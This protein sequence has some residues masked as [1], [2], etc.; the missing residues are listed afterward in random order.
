MGKKINFEVENFDIIEEEDS[1]SQFATAKVMAFATGVNKHDLVC[2]E[3]VLRR[4]ANTLY[5]KPLIYNLDPIYGDFG[6]HTTPEKSLIAGFCVPDSGEFIQL[7]DSRIGFSV[8]VKL[9]K[10]YAPIAMNILK[11]KFTKSVSVEMDLLDS[12]TRDDGLVDMKSFVFSSICLLGDLIN[13]AIESASLE[14]LSFSKEKEDYI[15]AYKQEFSKYDNVELEIPL[16]V[17]Q[18]VEKGLQ[19]HKQNG[20]GTSIALS[21]AHHLIKNEKVSPEK[22]RHIAKVHRSK[23]VKIKKHSS[24]EERTM[25]MLYGGNEG[26]EWAQNIEV[27]LND[28]DAMDVSYFNSELTFPYQNRDDMNPALRGINPPI[29]IEQGEEIAK[30]AESIGNDEDK[31]GWSIAISNFKKTHTVGDNKWVKK[32]TIHNAED[33]KEKEDIKKEDMIDEKEKDLEK[34]KV[35]TPEEEKKE[36]PKEEEKEKKEGI[37]KPEDKKEEKMSNDAFLDV[38]AILGLL[39]DETDSYKELAAEFES[40]EGQKDFSKLCNAMYSKMCKM[41]EDAK[42]Y[43]A[44]NEELKKFKA[45]VEAGNK[46]FE[47]KSALKEVEYVLPKEEMESLYADSSNFSLGEIEIWKNK[48]KARAFSLVNQKNEKE[49]VNPDVVKI[50]LPFAGMSNKSKSLWG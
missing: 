14:M 25:F 46:D 28:L 11:D 12:E 4:T 22:V 1:N 24:L 16:T 2:S 29:S 30:Q 32:E 41:A 17:K 21:V 34:E 8:L 3:E 20:K 10:R 19:L 18:N 42:T 6:S 5:S 26:Q 13:P 37:E 15:L 39:A 45:D 40:P 33:E 49:E 48:V 9:W 35:E 23:F 43:M 47:V 50:G 38:G 27:K 36:T 31:N 44:E 7:E